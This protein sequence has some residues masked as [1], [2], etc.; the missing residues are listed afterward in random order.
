MYVYSVVDVMVCNDHVGK[1]EMYELG[2]ASRVVYNREVISQL[3]VFCTWFIMWMRER[4]LVKKNKK[5][6]GWNIF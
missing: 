6:E 1:G 4:W 3:G 5:E 2:N